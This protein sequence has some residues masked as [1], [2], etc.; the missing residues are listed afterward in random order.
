MPFARSTRRSISVGACS[1]LLASAAVAGVF[2]PDGARTLHFAF[3]GNPNGDRP[4]IRPPA[5][6]HADDGFGFVDSPGL[7]GTARGVTAPRY[8]RYDVNVPP[9]TYEV[10]VMLGGTD[11]E[12]VTNINAESRPVVSDVHVARGQTAIRSFTVTVPSAEGRER[13]RHGSGRLSLEFEG[14]DPSLMKLDVKPAGQ[15]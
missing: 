15:K 3:E 12:S 14:R 2:F 7:I 8:F 5:F 11:G 10:T 1:L 13:S 6:Y 9:G 4:V